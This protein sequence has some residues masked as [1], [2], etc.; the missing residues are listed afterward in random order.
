M[1]DEFDEVLVEAADADLPVHEVGDAE[2]TL[3][4]AARPAASTSARELTSF[5][6]DDGTW[7]AHYRDSLVTLCGLAIPGFK[8]GRRRQPTCSDCTA[9]ARALPVEQTPAFWGCDHLF[10]PPKPVEPMQT[11]RERQ[12]VAWDFIRSVPGGVSA[13]EIGAHWHAHRGKHDEDH[14]CDYCAVDGK[15]VARSKALKRLVVYRRA[16]G[17]FE[18]RDPAERAPEPQVSLQADALPGSSFEDIFDMGSAA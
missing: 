1:S 14:R 16:T 3:P 9:A 12:Q 10:E 7:H 13:D 2:P 11:L 8:P 15:G 18:P 5:R 6:T 17:K 4:V